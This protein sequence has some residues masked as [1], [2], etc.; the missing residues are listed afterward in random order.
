MNKIIFGLVFISLGNLITAAELTKEQLWAIALT[1]IMTERNKSNYDTLNSSPMDERNKNIWLE[2][3]RRDWGINNRDEL[4]ETLDKMEH[5]GHASS[6]K[7]IQKIIM[8]T[9]EEKGNFSIITIYNK[10]QLNS[11]QYNYLKFTILNWNI[12][13]NRDILVWDLG[14]NIAL[15]R[16]GY[17][18]GFLTEEEALEKI[19]YYAK[20]IQPLY[21][22]WEEYGYD[23]Y[24]G[25]VFWASGF[26]EDV[27]YLLETYQIYQKL[28]GENG[29]WRNLEWNI[30]LK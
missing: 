28:I 24:M 18:V 11:R 20:L 26:G 25:R 7:F 10:Y 27:A 17:D 12:F 14:R 9:I 23:Y 19:M 21:N 8:E 2:T 22:S 3:L 29:Y 30:D 4:L 16:W 15:C 13:N 5:D 1:G 6:L